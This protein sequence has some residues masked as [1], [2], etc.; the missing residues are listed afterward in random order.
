M[1]EQTYYRIHWA[2]RDATGD[3]RFCAANASSAW[4]GSADVREPGYSCCESADDLVEYFERDDCLDGGE[5]GHPLVV[6]T[7]IVRW[8]TFG[9]LL[10]DDELEA[11][12]FSEET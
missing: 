1:S 6:P 3:Y 10:A 7:E 4:W 8:T 5:D 2:G 9:E 12:D 11:A